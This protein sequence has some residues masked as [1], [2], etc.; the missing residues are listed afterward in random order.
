MVSIGPGRDG[1][2]TFGAVPAASLVDRIVGLV[3]VADH[4]ATAAPVEVGVVTAEGFEEARNLIR[5]G[6]PGRAKELLEGVP[7]LFE[8]LADGGLRRVRSLHRSSDGIRGGELMWAVGASGTAVISADRDR[9]SV[10]PASW[11][12]V[13]ARLLDLLPG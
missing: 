9:A 6:D 12:D 1:L 13:R 7:G 2:Y 10:T 3:L 5:I 8:L 11:D 4:A